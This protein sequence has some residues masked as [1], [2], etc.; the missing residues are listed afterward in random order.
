LFARGD[1][2]PNG[3][4]LQHLP[5]VVEYRRVG[6]GHPDP[7]AIPQNVL[8]YIVNVSV[9]VVY[10]ILKQSGQIVTGG[11]LFGNENTNTLADDLSRTVTEELL[12]VFVKKGDCPVA[13][14]T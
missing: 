2:A 6:P 11:L 3:K 9:G 10:N 8:V 4:Y 5:V 14:P 13:L 12:G 1:I 7:A